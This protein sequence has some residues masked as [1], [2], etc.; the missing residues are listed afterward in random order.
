[1][2]SKIIIIRSQETSF[3]NISDLDEDNDV[4]LDYTLMQHLQHFPRRSTQCNHQRQPHEKN[5]CIIPKPLFTLS[6]AIIY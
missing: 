3:T 2:Y 6:D 5:D 1:M 4:S